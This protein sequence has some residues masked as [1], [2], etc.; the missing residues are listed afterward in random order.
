MENFVRSYE[1]VHHKVLK[2]YIGLPFNHDIHS[3]R[4]HKWRTLNISLIDQDWDPVAQHMNRFAKECNSIA[5]YY[6]Q[7]GEVPAKFETNYPLHCECQVVKGDIQPP[8]LSPTRQRTGF[9]FKSN[10]RKKRKGKKAQHATPT[11]TPDPIE[12]L[13]IEI[14]PSQLK[15]QVNKVCSQC[16]ER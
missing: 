15:F 10:Q 1:S 14:S 12:P 9:H 2:C 4:R 8:K 13:P 5:E 6:G 7:V 3:N 16:K 11:V